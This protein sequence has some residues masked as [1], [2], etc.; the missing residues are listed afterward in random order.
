[1]KCVLLFLSTRYI[2]AKDTY[3]TALCKIK[4]KYI[5]AA[6]RAGDYKKKYH[7]KESIYNKLAASV[8]RV[9]RPITLLPSRLDKHAN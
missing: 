7:N 3:F 8:V 2:K 4:D 5:I 9:Q 6:L 1:M